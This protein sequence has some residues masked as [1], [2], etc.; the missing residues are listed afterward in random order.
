VDGDLDSLAW[1]LG[2]PLEE[3]LNNP[4]TFTPGPLHNPPNFYRDF[5]PLKGP[6]ALCWG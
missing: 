3:V 6:S 2:N 5:H 1:D 4:L